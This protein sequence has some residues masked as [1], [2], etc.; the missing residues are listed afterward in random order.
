MVQNLRG[1][2]PVVRILT[3]VR[4]DDASNRINDKHGWRRH[5]VAQQIEH[6]VGI[7]HGVIRVGQDWKARAD[8]L[9]HRL[10]AR[11]V[12]KGYSQDFGLAFFE[13]QVR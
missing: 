3:D 10:S 7:R 8:Q 11:R 5:A 12:L 9:S 13:L 4:P 6:T 1:R 2:R